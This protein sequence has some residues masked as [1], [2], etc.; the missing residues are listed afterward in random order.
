MHCLFFVSDVKPMIYASE[1]KAFSVTDQ[2]GLKAQM[3]LL[4]VVF[5]PSCIKLD[6]P[7]KGSIMFDVSIAVVCGHQMVFEMA[8]KSGINITNLLSE[9]VRAVPSEGEMG[10][11]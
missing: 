2:A 7:K 10:N 1:R 4:V 5:P 9:N 8:L 6:I 11:E 3:V